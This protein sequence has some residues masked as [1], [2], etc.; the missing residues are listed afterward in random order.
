MRNVCARLVAKAL[1]LTPLVGLAMGASISVGAQSPVPVQGVTGTIATEGTVKDVHEAGNTVIVGT[2][3]G[4]EHVF[5]YTKDLLVH[6]GKGPDALR[7]LKAGSSVVVHYTVEGANEAAH[8]IDRL[9]D[10]G[11]K[12]TEGV[13]TRVDRRRKQIAIKFADGKTETFRLTDRA[14]EDAGK[15][16]RRATKDAGQ[17][18]VYYSDEGGQK[19][20]H[21]FKQVP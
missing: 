12:S 2:V 6:G 8:E 10:E 17:V 19:V 13:V 9:G 7:G 1:A 20:A 15:E 3:D 21:F 5:H 14:A 18:I 16:V 11:L 4:V